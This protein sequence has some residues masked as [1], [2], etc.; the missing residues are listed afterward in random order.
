MELVKQDR[1]VLDFV[2]ARDAQCVL[3][4]KSRL[5]QLARL[6]QRHSVNLPPDP[7]SAP[8]CPARLLALLWLH[9]AQPPCS[10]LERKVLLRAGREIVRKGWPP[11][12]D[13]FGLDLEAGVWMR[14][15]RRLNKERSH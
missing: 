3:E 11:P 2:A 15:A 13:E 14:A 9:R 1:A 8:R 7:P 10:S 5:V 6:A 12:R 4:P